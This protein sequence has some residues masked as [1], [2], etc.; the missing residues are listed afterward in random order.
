M[1]SM[2]SEHHGSIQTSF[3]LDS[4]FRR[5]L[6]VFMVFFLSYLAARLGAL[7]VL[8]P[9]MIWPLWPGCAFLV[10]VILLTKRKA[11]WPIFLVA[12]L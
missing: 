1:G 8:R 7:L 12:G 9:Q 11:F 4:F 6:A 2:R 3:Q 10:A 5:L